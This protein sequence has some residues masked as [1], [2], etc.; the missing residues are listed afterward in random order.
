VNF[1]NIRLPVF[2]FICLLIIS[3][4]V[5]KYLCKYLDDWWIVFFSTIGTAASIAGLV[6][7]IIQIASIESTTK[8]TKETAD[9]TKKDLLF[10]M[11]SSDISKNIKL[12]HEI[13]TYNRAKKYEASIMRMQDLTYALSQLKN[14]P[15][16]SSFISATKLKSHIKEISINISSLEKENR[17]QKGNLDIVTLNEDLE[18]ISR[19]LV[20][21]DTKLKQAGGSY[22]G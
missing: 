22:D 3:F 1:K 14:D 6:F 11:Y 7:V 20:D 8:L 9:K 19:D 16:L 4:I 13:E 15:S 10:Y 2:I 17:D 21:L 12:V 5:S 18:S